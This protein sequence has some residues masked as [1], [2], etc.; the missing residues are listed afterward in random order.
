MD[1]AF[2][3]DLVHTLSM[4]HDRWVWKGDKMASQEDL[5]RAMR[6]KTDEDLY[7]LVHVHSQDF[8]P[9]AIEA[10]REEFTH[11]QLDEPTRARI[12]AVAERAQEEKNGQVAVAEKGGLISRNAWIVISAL[13]LFAAIGNTGR[14]GGFA[15]GLGAAIPYMLGAFIGGLLLFGGVW[16]VLVL[17]VPL[18]FPALPKSCVIFARTSHGLDWWSE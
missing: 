9:E 1:L 10:A 6:D 15:V 13:S 18:D 12:L 3:L 8:T 5:Q 16:A 2:A 14:S 17:A 7:L 11:R 4:L